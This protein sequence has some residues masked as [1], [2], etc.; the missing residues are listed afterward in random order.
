MRRQAPLIA[1][2]LLI[3]LGIASLFVPIP[4]QQTHG[5]EIGEAEIGIRTVS[6]ETVHPAISAVLIGGGILV[7]VLALRSRR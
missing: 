4:R 1:A 2:I 5:F 3:G 7:L 6:R